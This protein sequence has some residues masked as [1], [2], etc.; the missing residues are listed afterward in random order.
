MAAATAATSAAATGEVGGAISRR[1][2][3]RVLCPTRARLRKVVGVGGHEVAHADGWTAGDSLEL[4]GV[5]V[6]G[7]RGV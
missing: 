7:V 3:Q 1:A 6:E 2:W 4:V 5:A